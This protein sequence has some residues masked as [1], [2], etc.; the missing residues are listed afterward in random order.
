V[1]TA[2]SEEDEEAEPHFSESTTRRLF[3]GPLSHLFKARNFEPFSDPYDVFDAVFG[4]EVFP[5][6]SREEIGEDDS[7]AGPLPSTSGAIPWVPSSP[8]SPGAW[9][10]ESYS[11]PDGKTTVFRTTRILHDRR[12]TRIETVKKIGP[13]QTK[14]HVTVTAEPLTPEQDSEDEDT[15]ILDC[16]LCNIPTTTSPEQGDSQLFE[17]GAGVSQQTVCSDLL[18]LYENLMVEMDCTKTE[19]CEEWNKLFSYNLP[20]K[21]TSVSR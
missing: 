6:V 4:S 8:R 12:M 13:G 5:R 20:F 10:G 18:Q 21:L 19:F 11:S 2:S 15:H 17:S 9:N 1:D 3:G 14:I 16:L 7:K